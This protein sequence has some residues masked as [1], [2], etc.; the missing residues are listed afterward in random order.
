MQ[1]P[2]PDKQSYLADPAVAAFSQRLS[3]WLGGEAIAAHPFRLRDKTLPED[4]PREF[5]VTRL[6]EC[7]SHYHWNGLDYEENARARHALRTALSS[8][9]AAGDADALLAAVD[10]ALRWSTGGKGIKLYSLNAEWAEANRKELP[11]LLGDALAVL[12]SDT[13]DVTAFNER[14]RMNVGFTKV[15]ALASDR[16]TMYDGRVG[17]ALGLLAR[18][19]CWRARIDLPEALGFPWAPGASS[20]NRNP[21]DE[22]YH[23]RQLSNRGAFHAEWMIRASWLIRDAASRCDAAWLAHADAADRVEAALFMLGYEIPTDERRTPA[24]HYL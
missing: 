9:L 23:F 19:H 5:T 14:L 7:F 4:A 13:P 8:A 21:S 3:R 15:Y 17:A 11:R 18:Q 24:F 10:A 1:A 16:L 12:E 2:F 22:R 6:E 20:L